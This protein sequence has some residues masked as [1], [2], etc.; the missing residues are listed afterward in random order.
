MNLLPLSRRLLAENRSLLA[1][2]ATY[3]FSGIL[4]RAAGLLIVPIL[5]ATLPPGDFTRYG[6]LTS[7]FAILLP[8][9]SL[10]TH[11]APQRLFYDYRYQRDQASLLATTL[12]AAVGFSLAGSILLLLVDALLVISDPLSLGWIGPKVGVAII[13][14]LMV[15]VQ[16]TTMLARVKG[17]AGAYA[18]LTGMQGI[19]LVLFFLALYKIR[20]G[21]FTSLLL[22]YVMTNL[23]AALMGYAFA[24]PHLRGGRFSRAQLKKAIAFSWPTALHML[25]L[26]S[27]TFSGRWIGTRYMSLEDL[28]PFVLVSIIA[29]A[30][31]MLPRALYDARMPEIGMAFA[32]GALQRGSRIIRRITIASL[33]LLGLGYGSLFLLFYG[34]DLRLPSAYHPTP[35]L[36]LLAALA[37]ALDA[38]YLQG[39]QILT[40]LKKTGTQALATVTSGTAT[41][42]LSF[43][44]ARTYGNTGLILAIVI[45]FGMQ[46]ALS[47]I[48]A[49]RQ[50][51]NAS[52]D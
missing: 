51:N 39:I 18:G 13:V 6:L 23:L 42:L 21:D 40:A 37:S 12:I 26:W 3:L 45:G 25:A 27:I 38:L 11:L 29:N 1:R 8:L 4:Q 41:I 10:N 9:F 16:F 47:S 36:L 5:V 19:G 15:V 33:F 24:A 43:L 7:T 34:L 46:A 35:V 28:A 44:L 49:Q 48:V 32:E 17:R 2:G 14:V 31:S 20:T 52:P 50:L 22:A 30:A